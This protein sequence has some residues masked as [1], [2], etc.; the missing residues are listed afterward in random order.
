MIFGNPT[1]KMRYSNW[2]FKHNVISL[3][4]FLIGAFYS[5]TLIVN[6]MSLCYVIH[7]IVS[8]VEPVGAL[9]LHF[10]EYLCELL[11][12]TFRYPMF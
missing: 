10:A 12:K 8:K 6:F 9:S 4:S 11:Y 7:R 5:A 2:L 3:F 1:R